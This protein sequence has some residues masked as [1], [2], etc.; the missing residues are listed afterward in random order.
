MD[1]IEIKKKRWQGED[2]DGEYD[3]GDDKPILVE[4]LV[5]TRRVHCDEYVTSS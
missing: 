5:Y 3:S 2:E 1:G 4:D